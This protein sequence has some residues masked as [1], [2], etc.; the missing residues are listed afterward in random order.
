M[1]KNKCVFE[2][3]QKLRKRVMGMPEVRNCAI[4][5]QSCSR[6]FLT[7]CFIHSDGPSALGSIETHKPPGVSELNR[8]VTRAIAG[9]QREI[10]AL[11]STQ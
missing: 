7:R 2:V 3:A 5:F 4:E 11:E 9:F 6:G 1:S 10:E 8:A